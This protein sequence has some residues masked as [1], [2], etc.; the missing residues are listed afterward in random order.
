M[1]PSAF[2]L[3]AK[4]GNNPNVHQWM[5]GQTRTDPHNGAVF[6][7]KKECSTETCSHVEDPQKRFYFTWKKTSMKGHT[8]YDLS[9]IHI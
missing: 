1:F 5:K 4:G 2:C 8:L 7:H 9:L 6:S 3:R